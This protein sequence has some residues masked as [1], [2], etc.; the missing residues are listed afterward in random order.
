MFHNLI[1]QIN[2][3]LNSVASDDGETEACTKVHTEKK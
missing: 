2:L 1:L 3:L